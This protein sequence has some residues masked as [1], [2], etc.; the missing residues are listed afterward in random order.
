MK[1]VVVFLVMIVCLIL[2]GCV[3]KKH[4]TA[5]I[6]LSRVEFEAEA[7]VNMLQDSIRDDGFW[8][9]TYRAADLIEDTIDDG[10]LTKVSFKLKT[11]DEET[12]VLEDFYTFRLI[13]SDDVWRELFAN[14]VIYALA[15]SDE[16]TEREAKGVNLQIDGIILKW[17]DTSKGKKRIASICDVEGDGKWDY[18]SKGRMFFTKDPASTV[19]SISE[20]EYSIGIIH[21]KQPKAFEV[22]DNYN[23]TSYTEELFG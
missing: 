19:I 17:E 9:S 4:D 20:S 3:E 12:I 6:D 14:Q 7:E 1:R 16:V 18:L 15:T 21:T 8:D 10:K 13:D 11:S 23:L 22:D 5:S 2:S